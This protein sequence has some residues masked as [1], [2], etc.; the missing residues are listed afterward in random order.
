MRP[1]HLQDEQINSSKTDQIKKSIFSYLISKESCS[2]SDLGRTMNLSIPTVTKIIGQLMQDGFVV[3]LGKKETAGGRRPNIYGINPNAGYF[4]GVD[5][6][7]FRIDFALINL[8]GDLIGETVSKDFVYQNTKENFDQLCDLIDEFI[9]SIDISR[10]K[11]LGGGINICNRV[12]KKTGEAYNF[13]TA[14]EEPTL[15]ER[16]KKRLNIDI[17]LDNDS[18][19]MLYAEF[20]KGI[21]KNAQNVLYVNVDWGV[22]LGILIN[23]QLY[24]GKS[25]FSGEFG[26]IHATDNGV[27]CQCGKRGCLETIASG[28]YMYKKFMEKISNNYSSILTKKI[29]QGDTITQN[30]IIEAALEDDVL[31]IE[32]IEEIGTNLG[33]NI[34]GLINLFNPEMIIIG[35]RLSKAGDYLILPIK[36]AIKKYAANLVSSDTIITQGQLGPTVGVI[37]ACLLSRSKSLGLL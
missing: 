31:S 21:A 13:Y 33:T 10:T 24:Y 27:V 35:G 25:G 20:M 11:L 23:G 17:Y 34:A 18:R 14:E 30:D 19:S 1:L 29:Q 12:N 26:H 4:I 28:T 16:F 7:R 15:T 36:S 37:G 9:N 22:G 5:I 6:R 2:L 3:E 32:L 8:Q